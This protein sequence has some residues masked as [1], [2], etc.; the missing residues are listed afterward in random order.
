MIHQDRYIQRIPSRK[1]NGVRL[2][3]ISPI[4][5]VDGKEGPFPVTSEERDFLLPQT[6]VDEVLCK[7]APVPICGEKSFQKVIP[8]IVEK[9]KWGES[10]GYDAVVINCMVDP[11][12]REVR[13]ELKIPVIG[14]GRAATGLAA[15]VGERP[16]RIFPNSVRVNDL[17][18]RSEQ[19]LRELQAVSLRQVQ[20]RGVDVLVF[21]CAYL[22][23]ASNYIQDKIGVPVMATTEIALRTAETIVLLGILPVR[24]EVAANRISKFRQS[25]FRAK[26]SLYRLT[27]VLKQ[28]LRGIHAR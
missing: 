27:E 3:V 21:N 25:I 16:F 15:T 23:G 17:A 4:D 28:K 20:T 19:S 26:D 12:V 8:M 2:L 1:P 24:T 7:G 22:G 18:S 6:E 14:A 11:G 5:P 9:A 10:N 13:R